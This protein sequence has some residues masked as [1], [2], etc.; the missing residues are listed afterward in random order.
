VDP[1]QAVRDQLLYL[2]NGGNAHMSF[3]EVVERFP[4]DQINAFAPNTPY[5]PWHIVE[6][7]R[8]CQLDILDYIRDPNYVEPP[9]PEGVWPARDEQADQDRWEGTLA[10]FRNDLQAFKHM[11]Q[12]EGT[13]LYAGLPHAPQHNILREILVAADHNAYHIGELGALRQVMGNWPEGRNTL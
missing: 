9:F 1:D 5:T 2:L 8:L 13:D 7:M 12:D 10:G 4:L 3:D 6:H 11:V